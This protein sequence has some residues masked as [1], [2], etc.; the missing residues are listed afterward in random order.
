MATKIRNSWI[1]LLENMGGSVHNV[2]TQMIPRKY[3]ACRVTLKV[4]IIPI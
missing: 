1:K 4:A 3:I 2:R